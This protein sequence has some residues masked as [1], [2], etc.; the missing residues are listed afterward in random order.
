MRQVTSL[1]YYANV[2]IKT[3][4]GTGSLQA[5]LVKVHQAS[6]VLCCLDGKKVVG[7]DDTSVLASSG[8]YVTGSTLLNYQVSTFAGSCE[9]MRQADLFHSCI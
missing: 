4:K 3:V 5:Q 9:K 7:S 6:L 8:S 2:A 1:R